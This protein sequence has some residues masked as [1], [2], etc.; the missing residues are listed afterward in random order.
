MECIICNIT[1][2]WDIGVMLASRLIN[3]SAPSDQLLCVVCGDKADC[4]LCVLSLVI[5]NTISFNFYIIFTEHVDIFLKSKKVNSS[6][7]KCDVDSDRD[8]K[9]LF[10][11]IAFFAADLT[12]QDNQ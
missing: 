1:S 6:V 2:P 4:L 3:D 8:H 9:K 7:N 12:V 10:S 11:S 5:V